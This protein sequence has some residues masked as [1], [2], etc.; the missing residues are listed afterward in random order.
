MLALKNVIRNVQGNQK[1]L[2]LFETHLLMV[3]T[4]YIVLLGEKNKH[5]TNTVVL[6][7]ISV[8]IRGLGI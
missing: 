6:C 8:T 2:T 4:D 7:F 1:G 5:Y 3:F